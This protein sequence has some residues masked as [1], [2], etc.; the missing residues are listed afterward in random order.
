MSGPFINSSDNEHDRFGEYYVAAVTAIINS[1]QQTI[2]SMPTLSDS[3]QSEVST[4]AKHVFS[5]LKSCKVNN[6]N[7]YNQELLCLFNKAVNHA[8]HTNNR[9]AIKQILRFTTQK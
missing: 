6:L 9:Q 2:N 5:Y 8:V 4:E 3:T 1:D 7:L